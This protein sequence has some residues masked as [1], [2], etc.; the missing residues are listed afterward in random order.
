MFGGS[1]EHSLDAAGRFVMPARFRLHL[2]ETFVVTKG[3]GCI[4][5]FT[6]ETANKLDE[7]LNQVGNMLSLLLDPNVSALHRHFFSGMVEIGA[8]K[9]F[10]VQLSPELRRYAGIQNEIVI[11]GCGKFIELWNPQLLEMYEQKN[12]QVENLISAG[13]AILGHIAEQQ[14]TE[15][16]A[17]APQA[18][19]AE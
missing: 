11:R 3:I 4:A 6:R 13:S 2:G 1:F 14:P 17:D 7:E 19:S 9:Q 10:R 15:Q 18:G 12:A 8:D 16:D 5:V